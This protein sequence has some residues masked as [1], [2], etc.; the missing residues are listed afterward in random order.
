MTQPSEP[1]LAACIATLADLRK[2]VDRQRAE[3]PRLPDVDFE[4]DAHGPL[5]RGDLLQSLH[6]AVARSSP[7]AAQREALLALAA[8]A[9]R[10]AATIGP[11]T[12]DDPTPHYWL[13]LPRRDWTEVTQAEFVSAERSAGFHPVAN[14]IAQCTTGGFSSG[15]VSGAITYS[16]KPPSQVRSW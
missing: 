6:S 5:A 2:E 10:W 11:V 13:R 7:G 3:A 14:W 4:G 8:L 12:S 15:G 9:V 1:G 16:A